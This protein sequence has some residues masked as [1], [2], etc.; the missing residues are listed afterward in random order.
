MHV[1]HFPA[2]AILP[3]TIAET[4]LAHL[5]HALAQQISVA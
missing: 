2:L 5:S 1:Q 4:R 3:G